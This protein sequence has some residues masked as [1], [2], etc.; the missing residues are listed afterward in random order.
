LAIGFG[1]DDPRGQKIHAAVGFEE[2][3]ALRRTISSGIGQ[4]KEG[5]PLK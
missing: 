3:G 2:W 5:Q 4:E 1:S